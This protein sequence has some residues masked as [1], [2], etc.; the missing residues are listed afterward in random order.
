MIFSIL[1]AVHD[2]PGNVREL[3]NVIECATLL[4]D[5]DRIEVEH[6][7]MFH[8][9]ESQN[10]DSAQ[11]QIRPWSEVKGAQERDYLQHLMTVTQ[12][13]ICLASKLSGKFRADLYR[14]LGQYD[15]DPNFFRT[16]P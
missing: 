4:A 13:N 12:G 14:S 3:A 7:R 8:R 5:G 11:E 16:D 15:I 1:C 10:L 2:W 9:S 6:L